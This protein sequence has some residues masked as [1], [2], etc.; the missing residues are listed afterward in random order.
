MPLVTFFQILILIHH[1]PYR[2]LSLINLLI[3]IH[4]NN[5]LL[6][7]LPPPPT[8]HPITTQSSIS[9]RTHQPLRHIPLSFH[10]TINTQPQ[11]HPSLPS[12]PATPSSSNYYPQHSLLSSHSPSSNP[13]NSNTSNTSYDPYASL[14]VFVT[15]LNFLRNIFFFNPSSTVYFCV[16]FHSTFFSSSSTC[17]SNGSFWSFRGSL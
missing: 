16:P 12:F 14:H 7:L 2:Q 11:F 1:R 13:S 9:S 6:L 5:L 15:I 8:T 4:N 10:N 17:I 3:L